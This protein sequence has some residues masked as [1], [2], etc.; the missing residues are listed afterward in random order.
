MYLA[1]GPSPQIAA[2]GETLYTV[3]RAFRLGQQTVL[4]CNPWMKLD[5]A[6]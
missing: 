3:W 4:V 2:D 1:G 6:P 5:P